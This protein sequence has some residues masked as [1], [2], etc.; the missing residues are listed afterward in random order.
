MIGRFPNVPRTKSRA[1]SKTRI[2]RSVAEAMPHP[3]SA[4]SSRALFHNA[5]T[6]GRG[7]R[8][9]VRFVCGD[10]R[11]AFLSKNEECETRKKLTDALAGFR[12]VIR[13]V[14][15]VVHGLW[16]VGPGSGS[17]QRFPA[18]C[19]GEWVV[20]PSWSDR[21]SQNLSKAARYYPPDVNLCKNS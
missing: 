15:V 3:A 4:F 19:R 20:Q 18:D 5:L 14:D 1:R 11:P 7:L 10:L 6:L 12:A 2:E 17:G 16:L 13:T 8:T 9:K 21:E